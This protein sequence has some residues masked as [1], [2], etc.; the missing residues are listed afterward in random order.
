M[1]S[2]CR[3]EARKMIPRRSW[4]Y[5][6]IEACIISMLQ[7]ASPKDRGHIDPFFAQLTIASTLVLQCRTSISKGLS[8]QTQNRTHRTCSI[9]PV[10]RLSA[11]NCRDDEVLSCLTVVEYT[12]FRSHGTIRGRAP[13]TLTLCFAR[14]ITTILPAILI[15]PGHADLEANSP[16]AAL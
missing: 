2:A 8:V 12:R 6:G 15:S 10:G 4:S 5:R 11:D 9:K 1:T 16:S 14:N 3:G 7:Q 13:V